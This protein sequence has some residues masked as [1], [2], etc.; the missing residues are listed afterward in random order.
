MFRNTAGRVNC[1]KSSKLPWKLSLV[2][3]FS[4]PKNPGKKRHK[5]SI[6]TAA[7]KVPFTKDACSV[8]RLLKELRK[9]RCAQGHAFA[10][11]D[12]VS[13]AV[14]KFMP[15]TQQRRPRGRAR[16]A[17]VE[18]RE[19]GRDLIKPIEIRRLDVW[20]A[21]AG[22]IAIPEIVAEKQEDIGTISRPQKRRRRGEKTQS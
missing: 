2:N 9:C 10:F 15:S 22:Q 16:R 17:H 7:A 8:T 14:A 12:R 5:Q 20:M 21:K 18:L 3:D 4:S 13:D 1:G 11:L 19:S 6:T